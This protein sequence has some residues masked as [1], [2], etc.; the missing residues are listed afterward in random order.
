MHTYILTLIILNFLQKIGDAGCLILDC[1]CKVFEEILRIY[2]TPPPQY[3]QFCTF[4]L[5]LSSDAYL[6]YKPGPTRTAANSRSV[7]ASHHPSAAAAKTAASLRQRF[8]A[9]PAMCQLLNSVVHTNL[10]FPPGTVRSADLK[11]FGVRTYVLTEGLFYVS[12][13]QDSKIMGSH[14]HCPPGFV[15]TE[16]GRKPT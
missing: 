7:M 10:E 4:P 13:P 15:Q 6:V 9:E 8:S 12:D 3:L 11:D 14:A 16:M 1:R 2:S 5:L